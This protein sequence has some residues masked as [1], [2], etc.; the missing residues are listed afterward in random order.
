MVVANLTRRLL[1]GVSMIPVHIVEGLAVR[2]ELARE[3]YHA[4]AAVYEP[5]RRF[6]YFGEDHFEAA[7]QARDRVL[8]LGSGTGY[9][10]RR[11][12]R[13]AGKVIGI[14]RE[15]RMVREAVKRG[16]A[17][18]YVVGDMTNLPFKPGSF[19]L[20]ASLGAFHCADPETFFSETCRVLRPGGKALVLSEVRVIPLFVPHVAL[21]PTREA[22]RRSG[23]KLQSEV[24]ISGIYRLFRASKRQG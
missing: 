23:M 24:R 7:L 15:W 22:I 11:L 13:H 5:G 16:G 6:Y 20:C 9:L 1:T 14:E 18:Q 4:L 2:W 21:E 10:A 17:V 3:L 19:D 8:E 12:A